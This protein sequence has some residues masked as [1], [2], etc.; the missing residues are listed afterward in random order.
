MLALSL[1]G[2]LGVAFFSVVLAWWW[3]SAVFKGS[4]RVF[5]G[6]LLV[7]VAIG[8]TLVLILS[9]DDVLGNVMW[10]FGGDG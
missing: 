9:L 7:G 3:N 2:L 1:L 6:M 10:R 5:L 8:Y 4:S